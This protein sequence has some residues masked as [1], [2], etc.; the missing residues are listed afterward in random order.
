M[1]PAT[2]R[3][4]GTGEPATLWRGARDIEAS[5]TIRERRAPLGGGPSY[6]ERGSWGGDGI[7]VRIALSSSSVIAAR[8]KA[9]EVFYD[10]P[11]SCTAGAGDIHSSAV[12][13][14][15]HPSHGSI[16]LYDRH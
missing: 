10:T 11:H 8:T 2:H 1:G 6:Q 7:G 3:E 5:C 14:R 15:H 4:A 12:R 9:K 13:P 16:W